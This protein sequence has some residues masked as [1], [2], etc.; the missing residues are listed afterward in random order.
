MHEAWFIDGQGWYDA[1]DPPSPPDG[2]FRQM[3]NYYQCGSWGKFPVPRAVRKRQIVRRQG[4]D[5]RVVRIDDEPQTILDGNRIF[6]EELANTLI[7]AC[8]CW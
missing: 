6:G 1:N 5:K 2:E 3:I 4:G 8:D 7:D